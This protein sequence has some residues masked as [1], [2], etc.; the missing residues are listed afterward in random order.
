MLMLLIKELKGI[1]CVTLLKIELSTIVKY[2][3]DHS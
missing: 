2:K 1:C 3:F